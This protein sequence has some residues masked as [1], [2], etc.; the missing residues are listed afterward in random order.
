MKKR[1]AIEEFLR[2]IASHPQRHLLKLLAA[3]QTFVWTA[4]L[5]RI[6]R[7]TI[8][9]WCRDDEEFAQLVAEARALGAEHRAYVLWANHPFRGCRPPSRHSGSG[10]RPKPR[11]K[12]GVF[13]R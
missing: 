4:K 12:Y 9:R 5:T 10:L 3:G 8:W 11:F 1:A 13:P 6:S 7:T 2:R